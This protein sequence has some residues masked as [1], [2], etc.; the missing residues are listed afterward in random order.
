MSLQNAFGPIH[1]KLGDDDPYVRWTAFE[2]KKVLT[3][4]YVLYDYG[5]GGVEILMG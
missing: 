3:D 4:E 2:D 1:D 5:L